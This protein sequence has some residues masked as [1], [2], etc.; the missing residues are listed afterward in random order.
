[1]QQRELVTVAQPGHDRAGLV[2]P[3]HPKRHNQRQ[4]GP[5]GDIKQPRIVAVA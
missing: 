5:G 4:A 1:M 3:R 2:Q